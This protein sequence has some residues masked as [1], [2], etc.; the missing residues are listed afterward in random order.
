MRDERRSRENK[1]FTLVELLV[2]IA[3]IAILAGML[4]PALNKAR[5]TARKISCVNNLKQLGTS[6]SMYQADYDRI[7][8][9]SSADSYWFALLWPYHKSG[10]LYSCPSDTARTYMGTTGVAA[11]I[12]GG[13]PGGLSYL[14]NADIDYSGLFFK[15]NKSFKFPS[16]TLYS[17]DGS[18]NAN[19]V[20]YANAVGANDFRTPYVVG[21]SNTKYL[22]RHNKSIN[23][24]FLDGHA[25]NFTWTTFPVDYTDATMPV[26]LKNVNIFWRGN[27]LGNTSL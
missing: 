21:V 11:T 2:V 9:P 26:T 5:E 8:A 17:G 10:K 3:I 13:L 24:L 23:T 22:A 1:N 19:A 4:L 20:G 27:P 18:G 14:R 12:K 6:H 25:D 16:Q 7:C 15:K